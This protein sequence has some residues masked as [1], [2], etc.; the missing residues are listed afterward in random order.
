MEN[1][2]FFHVLEKRGL[3]PK[4]ATH[5]QRYRF[6]PFEL[7]TEKHTLTQDGTHLNLQPKC[8]ELLSI[9]VKN[10]GRLLEKDQLMCELWPDTFVEEANLSNL[11]ALL[12]K[13][14]GDSP[15]RSQYIKTVPKFGYRFTPPIEC[16]V[17][18]TQAPSGPALVQS[19][20]VIRIIVFPFQTS[21]GFEDP[22]SLA[23][24]L[25][26]AISSTLAELNSFAVRA[27]QVAM[28]FDPVRWEPR[29]VARE[30]DVDF[31]LTG[32]LAPDSSGIH[33]TIKLIQA[34]SGSLLWSK[35][36]VV[37]TSELQR[38][39]QGVVH[40]VVRSLVRG[41]A[42]AITGPLH[43]GTPNHSEA[44]SL[45]LMANQLSIK[46]T[47]ENMALARDL[48]IACVEKDPDFAPAWARL[49]RCYRFLEKFGTEQ[50]RDNHAAQAAFERAFALNPDLV[51]A[52]H[53]YTAI[54]ADMGQAEDAMVRLLKRLSSHQNAPEL[55]A[56]LVH[57]CRYCGQ[58]EASLAAH[59]KALEL[60]PNAR[61]SVAH[62]YFAL[63]DFERTL[64]WY[65][66]SAGL[67]LD[68]LALASMGR[69]QEARA[70]LWTRKDKFGMMP[71]PMHS[72]HAYL[73]GE[74]TKGIA[75]LRG[76]Q[77]PDLG[78]PEQRFYMARQAAR[79]GDL[80][81]ANEI[82]LR[83]VQEGYWSTISLLRDPWLEPLRATGEFHRTFELVKSREAQS[84]AAFINA[85]GEEILS[86]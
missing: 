61:T 64:F 18:I 4:E 25:P 22:D 75:I 73:E 84:H 60:D 41:G 1:P 44:Y 57:A 19:Q 68:A 58:P 45:Y 65:G 56:A 83:S 51:L 34:P 67:Y 42:D 33:A 30:A 82:L 54:Q 9:L 23:S 3:P 55:F 79:F 71:G 38:L 76:A 36:W 8:F 78:E 20:P 70:L 52:H 32:T 24:S 72:L 48:Y 47:P 13:A 43:T 16:P 26:D 15:A 69:E 59:R 63:G 62:T 17:T 12:R 81:L 6:G 53:L 2:R 50:P 29:I 7:D 35:S 86:V 74:S 77:T 28:G 39:H 14:L 11:I 10:S 21:R 66:T 40:L 5:R 27:T 80:N 37:A 31:I 46:R 49:G 85:G